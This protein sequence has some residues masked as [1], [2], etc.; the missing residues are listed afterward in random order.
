MIIEE[1]STRLYKRNQYTLRKEKM[2]IVKRPE[3]QEELKAGSVARDSQVF[4]FFGERFLCKQAANDLITLILSSGQGTVHSID[5][6]EEDPGRTL[7]RLMSFSLLPG[8]QIY[9]VS[10]SRIFHTRTVLSEI[11]E[12]AQ[13]CHHSGKPGPARKA[14]L[15]LAQAASLEV[16]G[17]TPFSEIQSN[18]WKKLFGFDKPS[19]DLGWADSILFEARG[20]IKATGSGL[21]EQYIAALKKGLPASNVLILLAETVDKRQKLYTYIKKNHTVVDC[22]VTPGASSGAQK[23]QKSVLREMMQRTLARF[24]KKISGDATDIF[25]ERVGFHPVAVV[26]ETEKLALFV[27]ERPLITNKDL[28]EMVARNREDALFELTDAFGKRQLG[29]SLVILSRLQDQGMHALAILATMRNYLRKQLLIKS[30]QM[31]QQPAW[32]RSI[33]ARDF[34]SKYLP[35]L[36]ESGEWGDLLAGHPYA[37]YMNF[38]KASDYSCSTLKI[39]LATVLGAEYRLKGSSLPTGL[40]LE[41]LFFSML[42][43]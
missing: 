1:G 40:V 11:W 23:E 5:G 10:D 22:G 14:I 4:L 34:Q 27:G 26:T 19:E 16:D 2:A 43:G 13:Q 25:F 36:K 12:K 30:L 33:S 37:L 7:S 15:A 28:E 6:D 21:L 8:K 32:N 17:A 29:R 9:S 3:F 18:E 31:R 38:I 41:E 39:R 20:S 24:G 35:A 42:K